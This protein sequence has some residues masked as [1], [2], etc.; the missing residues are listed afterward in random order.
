MEEEPGKVAKKEQLGGKKTE[1]WG[2]Q[3]KFDLGSE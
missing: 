3:G 2:V 1:G